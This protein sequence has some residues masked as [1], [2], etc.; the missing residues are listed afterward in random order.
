MNNQYKSNALE[1]KKPTVEHNHNLGSIGALGGEITEIPP[2]D[3]L[4][5][6]MEKYK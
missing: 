5:K 1:F 4:Y 2:E 6:W 3:V